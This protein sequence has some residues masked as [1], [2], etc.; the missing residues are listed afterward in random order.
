MF[1]GTFKP[2]NV[3]RDSIFWYIQS[4]SRAIAKEKYLAL[5]MI[6]GAALMSVLYAL[7]ITMA[8]DIIGVP[9]AIWAVSPIAVHYL[10]PEKSIS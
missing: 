5:G 7:G 4:L 3:F 10:L 8:A 2:L 9:M 1:A 6:A